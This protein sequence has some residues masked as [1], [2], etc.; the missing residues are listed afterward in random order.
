MPLS[1]TGIC[2]Q[3]VSSLKTFRFEGHGTVNDCKVVLNHLIR[4]FSEPLQKEGRQQVYYSK[5]VSSST[6]KIKEHLIPVNEIMNYFLRMDLNS[7][8]DKLV[9]HIDTYL[10]NALVIVF[11]TEEEDLILNQS[12]FQRSM[13]LE[14]INPESHLFQDKWARYKSADIF[15]N[16]IIDNVA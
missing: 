5:N 2:H 13:P 7:T 10:Q 9:H 8:K 12:G 4:K 1:T 6:K 15:S 11:V 3:I 16:I 14:Y